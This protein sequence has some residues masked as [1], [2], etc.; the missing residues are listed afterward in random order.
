MIKFALL[1]LVRVYRLFSPLKF[2]LPVPPLGG[3]CCRFYPSCSAFAEEA[4]TKH[5][6]AR[7]AWLSVKRVA[8]CHPWHEGGVD[9]VPDVN[10]KSEIRNPKQIRNPNSRMSHVLSPEPVSN[11][12][13][14]SVGFASS[15][16]IR[17]SNFAKSRRST[18]PEL[19]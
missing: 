9:L 16:D 18:H 17:I 10:P 8:R 13:L 7:G 1:T 12:R 6:A 15:F 14:S 11:F 3:V 5:G 4:I 2:L 19:P